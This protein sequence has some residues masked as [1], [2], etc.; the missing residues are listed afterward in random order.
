METMKFRKPKS[1]YFEDNIF[2]HLSG[3]IGQI[4]THYERS[5]VFNLGLITP[6]HT[7][8]YPWFFPSF[9]RFKIYLLDFFCSGIQLNLLLSPYPCFISLLYL[10]LYVLGYNALIS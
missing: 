3:P 6:L 10:D 4:D 5:F 1:N 7:I 2:L 8:V 9:L